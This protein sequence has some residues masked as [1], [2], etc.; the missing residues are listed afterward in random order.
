ME[1]PELASRVRGS[2]DYA[3]MLASKNF[4][5]APLFAFVI[6]GGLTGK[7]A[8]DLAANAYRQPVGR[9]VKIIVFLRTTDANSKAVVDDIEDFSARILAAFCGW[10]PG[11]AIGVFEMSRVDVSGLLSGLLLLEIDLTLPDQLRFTQ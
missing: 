1:I 4:P 11:D 3:A 10:R 5:A 9:G 8:P 2:G 6:F 7:G